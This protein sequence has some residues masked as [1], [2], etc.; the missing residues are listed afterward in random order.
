MLQHRVKLGENRARVLVVIAVLSYILFWSYITTAQFFA[1][2]SA[3][4]DLGYSIQVLNGIYFHATL[5]NLLTQLSQQGIALILSPI[6]FLN[7]IPAILIIQ[8][9][10]IGLPAYVIFEIANV[11][12]A[13]KAISAGIAVIYLLYFPLAGISL[14]DFHF[15]AFF[16]FLF[17]AGYLFL[18]KKHNKLAGIFLLLSGFVRFPYMIVVATA[19]FSIALPNIISF[20]K[21]KNF[22]ILREYYI[23]YSILILSL[24]LLVFQYIL[25]TIINPNLITIH[26]STNHNIFYNLNDKILGIVF[27]NLPLLFLPLFS[28]KWILPQIPFYGLVFIANNIAYEYPFLFSYW[29]TD[30]VIPFLFLGLIDTLHSIQNMKKINSHY[31]WNKKIKQLSRIFQISAK[32]V[33]LLL[34]AFTLVTV[35]YLQPYGP[36]NSSS[37]NNYNLWENIKENSTV[38]R[39]ANEI[40]DLIPRNQSYILAQNSFVQLFPRPA[41]KNI[42]VSPYNIGPNVTASDILDNKFPF[43]GGSQYGFLPINYVL[44]D[45]NNLHTLTEPPIS[46]GYPTMIQMAQMLYSSGKYGILAASNGI[47]LLKRDYTGLPVLAGQFYQ[48]INLPDGLFLSKVSENDSTP[49]LNLSSITVGPGTYVF[50][51]NLTLEGSNTGTIDELFSYTTVNAANK[52]SVV[53]PVKTFVNRTSKIYT[54]LTF[55]NFFD[56]VSLEY[57]F[58]NY[59]GTVKITSVSLVQPNPPM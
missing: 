35:V 38:Y 4:W 57:E 6:T 15:E 2:N 30:M 37:F 16:M 33:F 59:N 1:M 58:L 45:L 17:L 34:I 11:K 29:Y 41:I 28:K 47:Y 7:S 55:N 39:T 46:P 43:D 20:M 18:I 9:I 52:T 26:N 49:I 22:R 50:T 8:N 14:F 51:T 10:F 44:I 31:S 27:L 21:N 40:V 13:N 24:I 32:R 23:I 3:I 56:S 53:I 5:T 54:T 42:L 12:I 19:M 36:L 48:K 25:S